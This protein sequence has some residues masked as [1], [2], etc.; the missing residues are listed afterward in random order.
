MH[1]TVDSTYGLHRPLVIDESDAPPARRPLRRDPPTAPPAI[2]PATDDRLHL[3][4]AEEIDFVRR[5]IEALGNEISGDSLVVMRHMVS[6]QV[7]DRVAQV[8]GHLAAVTRS[9]NPAATVDAIGM[10]ELK[11]RLQRRAL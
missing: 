8:L 2:I 3:H 10:T 4:L 6:L 1:R 5:Q 11:A 7:F 9:S